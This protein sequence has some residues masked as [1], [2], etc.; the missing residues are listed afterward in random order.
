MSV[1]YPFITIQSSKS[2]SSKPHKVSKSA[3]VFGKSGKDLLGKSAKKN[4]SS[5]NGSV[6]SVSYLNTVTRTDI[7]S[8]RSNI[9]HVK[10][11][12]FVTT[13]VTIII[14]LG[15]TMF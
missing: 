6:S 7:N 9:S 12:W 10:E 14:S 8:S 2:K 3:K 1:F 15:T 4:G 5:W 11:W 13:A